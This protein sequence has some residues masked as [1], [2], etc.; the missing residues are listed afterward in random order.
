LLDNL[1][2]P[3]ALSGAAA[4]GA[5]DGEEEEEGE[6]EDEEFGARTAKGRRLPRRGPTPRERE[7]HALTHVPYRS[8]CPACVAG[9]GR[10]PEHTT[11]ANQGD[12]EQPTV[13]HDF[14]YPAAGAE[15][16]G[17]EEEDGEE[18]GGSER[19]EE[20]T[21]ELGGKTLDELPALVLWEAST[22][23]LAATSLPSKA[24]TAASGYGT[25]YSITVIDHDWGL[26]G[27]RITLRGD[28]ERALVAL[29]KRV[30]TGRA[31]R[32]NPETT[33]RGDHQSNGA[34]E[35]AVRTA[36]AHARTHMAA[37]AQK[38][39]LV[40]L[41]ADSPIL[42]W[43]V[44]HGP[45]CYHRFH[46]G[47]DGK[48]AWER[49]RGR[50]Y[51]AVLA[52]LGE[53]VLFL[54]PAHT[55]PGK[56]Q[57][58]FLK[59]V[60][61]GRVDRTNEVMIGY[62]NQL[63]RTT[64]FIRL[65][66]NEQFSLEAIEGLRGLLPWTAGRAPG[67]G[68]PAT[69]P[70]SPL[71]AADAGPAGPD[72]AAAEKSLYLTKKLLDRYGRTP[73]CP[74]CYPRGG[75][76]AGKHTEPCRTR[77][78]EAWAED[79]RR[80]V[81]E[82]EEELAAGGEEATEGEADELETR[83][84]TPATPATPAQPA[85]LPPAEDED[86]DA[87][88]LN[89]AWE[90]V[91][92]DF[93]ASRAE[94]STGQAHAERKRPR[95]PN[96]PAET[97]RDDHGNLLEGEEEPGGGGSSSSSAPA[98]AAAGAAAEPGPRG[99]KREAD[100]ESWLQAG[101]T[102]KQRIGAVAAYAAV[103]GKPTCT[104]TAE[105]TV[106]D[107]HAQYSMLKPIYDAAS[108]VQL[109][110]GLVR[111]ARQEELDE[112]H[113]HRVYRKVL[114]QMARDR[115]KRVIGVRWVDIDKGDEEN[116]N[117]RSRLVAKELRAF[118]PFAPTDE[119]FAATPPTA[120]QNLLL[121]MLCTRRS[122]RGLP[123]KLCFLDVRRAYFYAAATEE[124]YVEL[125][126]ED[127]EPGKDLIGRLERSLYGTRTGAHNWQLQLGKDLTAPSLGLKQAAGSPCLF[128]HEGEG[129]SLVTF[130]DDLWLLADQ[131]GLDALKPKLHATYTL[132]ENGTLGPDPEDD[133]S[134]RTLNRLVRYI[135][136]YGVELE[137]DPRHAELI[138]SELGMDAARP[139]G[140]P[141]AKEGESAPDSE[142]LLDDAGEITA[143]R[144]ISARGLYLSVDRPEARFATKELAR[145]MANPTRGNLKELKRLGRYLRGKPR[146]VMVYRLQGEVIGERN[147]DYLYALA[148]SNWADCRETRRST[149][150]GALMHGSHTLATWS[151]TQA[152]QA[153]SSG[154]A[155][156]YALLRGAV[157]VLG[158]AATAEELGFVFK[159]AP[160]VGSDSSAARSA[161]SRHGL[162]KLKHVELKHLW[163]QETIRQGR[164]VL[165]KE[166][167]EDNAADLLTK[168]LPEEK[169]HRFLEKLGFEYRDGRAAGA[170]ELAKGA[171]QRRVAAAILAGDAVGRVDCRQPWVHRGVAPG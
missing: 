90:G 133:K 166:L 38:L 72:T 102:R 79:A 52:Q 126:P 89:A 84:A 151:V 60:F 25:S 40:D 159:L 70:P 41:P 163:V 63:V 132:K 128:E 82:L 51:K 45:W 68:E 16:T 146:L 169:M 20:E 117:V 8:W 100:P 152:V 110:P 96:H 61:L 49:A 153:L 170:P 31:G 74:A 36:R 9:R 157:E 118:N 123:L 26:A 15:D 67:R 14:W 137:A 55:R 105:S 22:K 1:E 27:E 88:A 69:L 150:G 59:G 86:L 142:T 30:A 131:P 113:K 168:H 81:A 98:P 101:E 19:E 138:I 143:F 80:R 116:P 103:I 75:A 18:E 48:T 21:G 94:R 76:R 115:G 46:V 66:E 135:D 37:L 78:E 29:R 145:R 104:D 155:E 11:A 162:G 160:R 6:E 139:V 134:V 28:G 165:R 2:D 120:A 111:A 13:C 107:Q 92:E 106:L 56:M 164:V 99:E 147:P 121:S 24:A 3:G 108:G 97:Y 144:G 149:S 124:V 58:R 50:P 129:A 12:E 167:G 140:T 43:A 32:T 71:T 125:P 171:A 161:A 65:P 158:A 109:K 64:K 95:A 23:G 91:L 33:P 54:R 83:P 44:R 93:A 17:D 39:G 62:G 156:L 130:G 35:Q 4:A 141:G 85:T 57:G 47:A 10:G 42:P 77:V 34:A 127:Q 136:G 112:I 73:G 119:L 5:A 114:R 148:D 87:Q 154:E 122:K 53:I 7:E